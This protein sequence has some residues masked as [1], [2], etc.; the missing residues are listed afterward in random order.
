MAVTD[1]PQD[2]LGSPANTVA[3]AGSLDIFVYSVAA[4]AK[5]LRALPIALAL[6]YQRNTLN[7]AGAERHWR[8]HLAIV[9]KDL[10]SAIEGHSADET[11]HQHLIARHFVVA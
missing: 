9:A 6:C 11:S 1:C 5:D 8:I 3:T 2:Q 7:L 10:P 4:E